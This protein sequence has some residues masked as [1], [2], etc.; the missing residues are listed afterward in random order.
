M[1]VCFYGHP[2]HSGVHNGFFTNHEGYPEIHSSLQHSF[3]ALR[4]CLEIGKE[5]AWLFRDDFIFG[6]ACG[7]GFGS[8]SGF[9]FV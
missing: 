1:A 7:F 5:S 2:M 8:T 9:A 6:S 3:F 4:T